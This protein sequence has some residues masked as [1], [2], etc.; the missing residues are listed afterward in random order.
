MKHSITYLIVVPLIQIFSILIAITL[1][2][3][4]KGL[5]FF[6]SAYYIPVITSMVAVSITWKW[7]LNSDGLLN[8]IL[9]NF[10]I[11]DTPISFLDNPDFALYTVMF[12][13][14][15]KGLGYYMVIYLAGLQSIPAELEEAAK[16]DG[17]KTW[18]VWRY[19]TIPLLKPS[20]LLSSVLSA[21]AALRVFDE[22]YVMTGGGPMNS[23]IVANLYIYETAFTKYRFGY[24]AALG[25]FLAIVVGIFTFI[26]FKF[27]GGGPNYN[28]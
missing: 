9:V 25:F 24:A 6:R 11:L 15:W 27:L 16:I 7:L 3:K 23:T 14:L 13:T 19:I 1:N 21:M 5:S 26:N 28:E 17:A 22:V 20:I 4:L 12:V 8:N 2:R 10:G 18:Q